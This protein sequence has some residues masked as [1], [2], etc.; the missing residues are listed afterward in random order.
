MAH[1]VEMKTAAMMIRLGERN[2]T[3]TLNHAPCGS[4]PDETGG[5]HDYLA[6]ILPLGFSL[7]VLGTDANGNPFTR[8]YKGTAQ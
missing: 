7:T 3:L 2:G 4:E 5:C 1:H 8:T 6:R